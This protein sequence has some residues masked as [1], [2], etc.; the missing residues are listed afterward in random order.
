RVFAAAQAA[1]AEQKALD[2]TQVALD[3]DTHSR[4]RDA[5][6]GDQIAG[7]EGMTYV[8]AWESGR[9][10]RVNDVVTHG[11]DSWARL[12]AGSQ[13]TPGGSPAHWGLVARRGAG[14]GFGEL[15]AT[16]VTGLWEGVDTGLAARLAALEYRSGIRDVSSLA[17]AGWSDVRAKIGRASCRV[18]VRERA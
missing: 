3:A 4:A 8:G 11:G 15:A 17:G 6:L 18:G 7:M 13:G 9:A 12:T 5:A 14:G 10:Y 2:A 1:Q 16:A